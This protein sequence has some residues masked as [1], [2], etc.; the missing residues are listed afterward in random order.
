M[1][2]FVFTALQCFI[3]CGHSVNSGYVSKM[4]ETAN[5]SF[6]GKESLV[7]PSGFKNHSLFPSFMLLFA[8][9][10][11][12]FSCLPMFRFY[13]THFKNLLCVFVG[14]GICVQVPVETRGT[15]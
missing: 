7:L 3:N 5:G 4:R 1:S 14:G 12:S 11:C 9:I 8:F 6:L 10:S 2:G 15:H 13:C